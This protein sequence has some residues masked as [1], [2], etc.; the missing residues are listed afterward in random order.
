MV[1]ERKHIITHVRSRI[2][3]EASL[4]SDINLPAFFISTSSPGPALT[5]QMDAEDTRIHETRSALMVQLSN[6]D[7]SYDQAWYDIH[8]YPLRVNCG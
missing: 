6:D 7:C 1:L 4:Y 5:L 2:A 3:D 8:T